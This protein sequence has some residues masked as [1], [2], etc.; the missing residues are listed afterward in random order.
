MRAVLCTQWFPPEKAALLADIAEG[1]RDEGHQVTVLTG[2][3]NYPLG[4][5]YDG[6]RQ[7]LWADY[8][9][10]GYHV[11]RVVQYP[12]HDTSPVRRAASYISFGL[13]A[14]VFGWRAIRAA[15]VVYVYHPPLTTALGPWLSRL[16]G[17]PPFVLH[18]Q[19]LWPDSV[20]AADMLDR[21][22]APLVV[23]VLDRACRAVYRGAASVVCIAPTMASLLQNRGV[24]AARLEV[25]PNWAD[26]ALFHPVERDASVVE[27]LQLTGTTSVMFAGNMGPAQGLGTAI[28]AA[29][30]VRDLPDFRLVL[31]GDGV[32]RPALEEL[33]AQ[34]GADNVV[35]AGA[36]PLAEMNAVTAAADAQ[37]VI[38]R[39]LPFLRGTIPSKLGSVL[40]SGLPVVCAAGGDA[41]ALVEQA[42]AGWAC[43]GEDV[44]A[45]AEAF[46]EV[47]AASAAELRRRG[48]A[49]CSYYRA[50]MAKRRG[51]ARLEAVLRTAARPANDRGD[52]D[53]VEDLGRRGRLP[54]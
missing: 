36:R 42:G 38:L 8:P 2:F 14:A 43:A 17:G 1:L 26:E 22:S 34:L 37:L 50:N 24:S 27:S 53:L 23:R 13:A 45:L 4:K 47:H 6:W 32:H 33:A 29:A 35:F 52:R 41:R 10:E 39:D 12:S 16:L 40:A 19:D 20:A 21:R 51:V 15:D 48:A 54:T 49:G 11:R 46:R 31:V 28:R 7:R 9:A 3:P 30:A 18:V 5:V 44:A 25:V